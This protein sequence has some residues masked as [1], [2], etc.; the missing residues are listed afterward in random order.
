MIDN[1]RYAETGMQ[2]SH[3]RPACGSRVAGACGFAWTAEI[4]D[5]SGVGELRLRLTAFEGP[6]LAVLKMS[7]GDLP[8]VLP[9]I[10]AVQL[11]NRTRG[12]LGFAPR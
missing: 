8:R 2:P 11:K 5:P 9:P 12:A 1:E 7:P 10:D 4:A 3:R 6:G